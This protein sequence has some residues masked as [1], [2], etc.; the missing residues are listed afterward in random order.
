MPGFLKDFL[1]HKLT[2]RVSYIVAAYAT[3]HVVALAASPKFSQI[4]TNA[5]II[6]QV[7]D[8]M[9]FKTY[10]TASLLIGGEFA[11]HFFHEKFVIPAVNKPE[12]IK[13]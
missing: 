4:L 9:K 5:G 1:L 7:A 13:K 3:S 10:I 8:P 11:Y 12:E 2:L 6:F